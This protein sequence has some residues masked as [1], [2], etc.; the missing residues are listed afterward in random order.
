[1]APDM[2]RDIH[3]RRAESG[4]LRAARRRPRE[5]D[6]FFSGLPGTK[7]IITFFALMKPSNP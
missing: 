6:Y 3:V 5:A 2:W 7:E 4:P 1:M